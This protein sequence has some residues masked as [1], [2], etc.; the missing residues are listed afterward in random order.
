MAV[1]LA[2]VR[3]AAD[4][5]VGL[6]IG[7]LENVH[8]ASVF[9]HARRGATPMPNMDIYE[10]HRGGAIIWRRIAVSATWP[11][12]NV[13]GFA[14]GLPKAEAAVRRVRLRRSAGYGATAFAWLAEPKL[15]LR[16]CKRERR[17]VDLTGI[18]PVTS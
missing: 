11:R 9:G 1:T 13:G 4:V 16:V 17:L 12:E 14:Q 7:T 18:E 15:T 8:K 10:T 6:L 3:G 2:D 5:E